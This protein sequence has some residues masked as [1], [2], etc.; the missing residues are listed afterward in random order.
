[1]SSAITA[2]GNEG[3]E[4]EAHG[5]RVLIDAFFYPAPHVGTPPSRRGRDCDAA[6]A[7]LVTHAHPDHFRADEVA[8]AARRTRAPVIGP[9]SV[10]EA[11]RHL[12]PAAQRIELEPAEDANPPAES[13]TRVAGINITA[14]R[15][16]H[17]R[18]HNS[19]LVELGGLRWYHDGDNERTQSISVGRIGTLDVLFMAPWQGS[20]WVDFIDALRPRRWVL[21]H[22]TEEEHDQQ[23]RGEFLPDLCAHVPAGLSVLRPGESL[24]LA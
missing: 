15:T 18:G 20:G 22:L 3:F 17:A 9:R 16:F 4:I 1:M 24:R 10:I 12:L 13:A 11:L 14:L 8:E 6:D 19:Y 23:D 21:M 2:L 7:I 5:K